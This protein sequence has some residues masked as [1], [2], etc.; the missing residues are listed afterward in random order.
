MD[1]KL[2]KCQES[3]KQSQAQALEVK[4]HIANL[5]KDFAAVQSD[6]GEKENVLDLSDKSQLFNLSF[7]SKTK[8]LPRYVSRMLEKSLAR[9]LALEKKL[10]ESRQNEEDLKRKLHYTEQVALHMEEAAEVVWGRFL[11]A[12]NASE[13]LMG[14]SKELVGKYQVIQFNL[15]S[16]VQREA[17][18]ISKIEDLVE[19]LKTKDIIMQ[20]LESVNAD[21]V[22]KCSEVVNL[23][24]KVKI[25]E[26]Q[27]KET[28][29]HLKDANASWE[30]SQHQIDEMEHVV[31]TLKEGIEA[32]ESRVDAAEGK[33]TQLT[34][35]NLE[36]T[37]ELN[38]L[39]VSV[40][41]KTEKVSVL[42]KQSRDLELQLQH[43]RASS[44]ASQEQ[45]NMLYSAI[46][47]METLIEDLKSK[48]S[49]AESK[50]DGVEEQC[51]ELSEANFEL[52]KEVSL[53]RA[54]IRDLEM[55]LDDA[56]SSKVSIA[57]EVNLR[58]KIM[59]DTVMQLAFER[60]RIQ[61]QLYFLTKDETM[62]VGKLKKVSEE[63]LNSIS[64]D[65]DFIEREPPL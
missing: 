21:Y 15:N 24:D 31:E 60:E 39:K 50:T 5:Q 54:K 43:A 56:I 28:R 61:K 8:D 23:R 55:S 41:S 63:S 35:S 29:L 11:E 42:E 27:L 7:R 59:M 17:G 9:E 40:N 18:L 14:I 20:K 1:E 30:A 10:L 3:L 4:R 48:V 51:I 33:V 32:A 49:K 45:Q 52:K 53:L 57:D 26:E 62:L 58:T 12:D 16:S 25:L 2:H 64:P 47:D 44:E 38:F 22:A 37:E 6:K 46:W 65:K 19:Q 34:D 36:L 13:I